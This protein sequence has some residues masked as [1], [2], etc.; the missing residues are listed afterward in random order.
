M[1]TSL[2]LRD[3]KLKPVLLI[4]KTKVARRTSTRITR[5]N[6]TDTH[7][8]NE[9]RFDSPGTIMRIEGSNMIFTTKDGKTLVAPRIGVIPSSYE[10]PP[11]VAQIEGIAANYLTTLQP[12]SI[13][14][15]EQIGTTESEEQ[16][17]TESI[18][19][20]VLIT[21]T[22]HKRVSYK[23]VLET[24]IDTNPTQERQNNVGTQSEHESQ[25]TSVETVADTTETND[26][27]KSEEM[28]IDDNT[29]ETENDK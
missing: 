16:K 20:N 14:A 12:S 6:E 5:S 29:T 4:D 11:E 28:E 13:P 24:T 19:T 10:L 7:N 3:N 15:V 26:E 1:K 9:F 27:H 2:Q 21:P 25:N 22:R 17:N 18:D 23:A 8:E